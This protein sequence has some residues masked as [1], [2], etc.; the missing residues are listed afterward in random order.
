MESK[1]DIIFDDDEEGELMH[2]KVTDGA[3]VNADAVILIYVSKSGE[4]KSLK[5]CLPGVVTIDTTFEKRKVS[6]ID[7]DF[8]L[9][10]F[11]CIAYFH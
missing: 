7:V 10:I 6:T 1:I 3:Y 2:W 5:T 4:K 11:A 8:C 9:E